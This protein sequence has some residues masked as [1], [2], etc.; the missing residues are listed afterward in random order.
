[1]K[2]KI[3]IILSTGEEYNTSTTTDKQYSLLQEQIKNEKY[4][5]LNNPDGSQISI[6]CLNIDKIETKLDNTTNTKEKKRYQIGNKFYYFTQEDVELM[7][8]HGYKFE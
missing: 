5:T 1:M 7:K 4:L 2:R 8:K 6:K 3:K